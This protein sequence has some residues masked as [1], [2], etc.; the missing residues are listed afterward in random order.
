M[1][2]SWL[3]VANGRRSEEGE[4]SMTEE[5]V[6]GTQTWPGIEEM[7]YG[8]K[9]LFGLL[10]EKNVLAVRHL[11]SVSRVVIQKLHRGT[12]WE[13]FLPCFPP[14]VLALSLDNPPFLVWLN[15][16]V[17]TPLHC[18]F[19][20]TYGNSSFASEPHGGLLS[21]MQNFISCLYHWTTQ[22]FLLFNPIR[23]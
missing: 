17:L 9:I 13:F 8:E 6:S 2:S 3:S 5:A 19:V 11:S 1:G 16:P 12:E 15:L 23:W 4:Q 18:P 22:E 7:H 21:R 14:A 20:L 10:V